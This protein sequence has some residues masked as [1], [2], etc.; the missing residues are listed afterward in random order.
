MFSHHAFLCLLQGDGCEVCKPVVA[1]ILASLNNDIILDE[2]AT[3]QDTN[4][5]ALANMQR[6]EWEFVAL[7][8]MSK[9][10]FTYRAI[11]FAS[12][13]A[14]GITVTRERLSPGNTNKPLP[15]G[16]RRRL[17]HKPTLR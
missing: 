5:R 10:H 3:L 16:R 12:E 1:S 8:M 9:K 2:R 6:G 13:H 7:L 11:T 14:V 17:A 15:R 4:D